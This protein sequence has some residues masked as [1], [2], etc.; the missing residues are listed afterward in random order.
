MLELLADKLEQIA[1]HLPDPVFFF[2]MIIQDVHALHQ[3]VCLGRLLI[4][5]QRNQMKLRFLGRVGDEQRIAAFNLLHDLREGFAPAHPC[6]DLP[7]KQ[8]RE[9]VKLLVQRLLRIDGLRCERILLHR[10]FRQRELRARLDR[11]LGVF[12]RRNPLERVENPVVFI[13]EDDVGIFAHQFNVELAEDLIADFITQRNLHHQPTIQPAL[14]D[15]Q[16]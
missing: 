7:S 11:A 10:L 14:L 15:G 16:N 5:G 6:F 13:D 1:G 2:L 3:R 4:L 9:A 12:K 8:R